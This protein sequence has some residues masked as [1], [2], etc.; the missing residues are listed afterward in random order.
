MAT[1]QVTGGARSGKSAWAA[2]LAT[3]ITEQTGG[4]V[5]FVATAEVADMEMRLRVAVHRKQRPRSWKTIEAPTGI[6]AALL[7]KAKIDGESVLILDCV[8]QL[9]SNLMSG[10]HA[11][12]DPAKAEQLA[13]AELRAVLR[14]VNEKQATIILVSSELGSGL[15]PESDTQ[16]HYRD[17]VGRIN[18]WLTGQAEATWLVASG[19]ALPLHELAIPVR[20]PDR[21]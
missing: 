2:R 19:L 1:I 18:Q 15:A 11:V 7:R 12:T 9:V 4:T 3:T 5:I 10:E 17:V 14:L 13:R 8:A 6:A 16:R 20:L 21:P